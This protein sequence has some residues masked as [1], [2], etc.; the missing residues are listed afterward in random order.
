MCEARRESQW[1]GKK[2]VRSAISWVVFLFF[3][4]FFFLV[5]EYG[6]TFEF[7]NGNGGV[8]YLSIKGCMGM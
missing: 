2:P 6:T 3:N 1:C 7:P 5:I 8:V 4:F